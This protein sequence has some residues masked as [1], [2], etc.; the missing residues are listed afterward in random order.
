M[1]VSIITAYYNREDYVI[2]SIQ[3]LLNQTYREIEILAIDDGS[4]DRTLAMLQSIEDRR[5]R[6]ITHPNMGLVRSFIH[7]IG[8]A[9]GDLIAIHGSG[10]YSYP[11]RI[12]KQI[13][14]LRN[15]PEVGV[16]GCQVE[17][18]NTITNERS[19]YDKLEEDKDVTEQLLS[20]NNVFTHGEVMFRRSVYLQAGG[21]RELFTYTQ[22][23]DLW[24]RM[25]LVTK[26]ANVREVLY[27]RYTLPGGVG[28]SLEKVMLQQYLAEMARQCLEMR[29]RSGGDII[30]RYGTLSP[31]LRDR[32]K[33]LSNKLYEL[34]K[35]ALLRE[36]D[37]V[38]AKFLNRLSLQEK[39]TFKNL[40]FQLLLTLAPKGKTDGKAAL[41]FI[42]ALRTMK[43]KLRGIFKPA[44]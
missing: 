1:L 15:R 36:N 29:L 38:R 3:S 8:Q 28:A 32:T 20:K 23:Y 40:G 42:Q 18:V 25:S 13:E 17:N 31:F 44:A 39:W 26:F 19:I 7:A 27:R 34:A 30:D 21:Y 11:E 9:S 12:E 22:D 4:T 5:L 24:L 16:V 10:D 14:L 37:P 2:E 43:N 35:K 6:V 33:R 41:P